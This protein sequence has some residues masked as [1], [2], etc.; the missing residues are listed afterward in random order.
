MLTLISH[1]LVGVILIGLVALLPDTL[2]Q[3]GLFVWA[4]LLS[5]GRLRNK[6]PFLG[7]QLKLNIGPWLR[8]LVNLSGSRVCF[9]VSGFN[10]LVP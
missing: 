1:C 4:D 8:L 6:S 7:L 5:L 3:D 2:C 10:I 9:S